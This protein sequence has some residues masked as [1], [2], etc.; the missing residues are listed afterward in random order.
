M[1]EMIKQK[2]KEQER[3]TK[4]GEKKKIETKEK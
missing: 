2:K 3:Q 1:I 4:T